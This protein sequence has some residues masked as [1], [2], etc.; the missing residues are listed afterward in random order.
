MVNQPMHTGD[1]TL[2]TSHVAPEQKVKRSYGRWFKHMVSFKSAKNLLSKQQ[3]DAIAAAI[4][5]AEMGHQGEIQVVIEG[6]LPA[7]IALDYDCR[8][9]AECLFAHYRV[10]DTEYNSGVLIYLNLCEHQLELVADRG[11]NQA[12]SHRD[13]STLCEE[14]TRHFAQDHYLEG[15]VHGI[16]TI[17]QLIQT[18]LYQKQQVVTNASNELLDRAYIL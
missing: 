3:L 14:M 7:S 5:S 10:W 13:W 4:Q 18:Y 9:R 2:L 8:H 12:V 6:H 1:K 17:S 16:D 11:I 15:L